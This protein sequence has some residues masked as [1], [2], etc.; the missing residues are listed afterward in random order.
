MLIS[1]YH[2][3]GGVVKTDSVFHF[4]KQYLIDDRGNKNVGVNQTW[5]LFKDRQNIIWAPNQMNSILK[6]NLRTEKMI[7]EKDSI[8]NG[9]IIRIKQDSGNIIWLAHWRRG[10]IKMNPSWK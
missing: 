4:K 10:L 7:N 3:N 1:F 8:L 5:N 6:L 2:I 9:P